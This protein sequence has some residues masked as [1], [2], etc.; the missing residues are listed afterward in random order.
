[1][2]SSKGGRPSPW[3]SSSKTRLIR[4]PDYMAEEILEVARIK[5]RGGD[6]SI[7]QN[8]DENTRLEKVMELI[9]NYKA[10]S[11]PTSTRWQLLNNFIAQLEEALLIS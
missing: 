4:V 8:Q 7:I 1:M 2:T 6:I 11:H 3:T 10:K 9:K 5:D